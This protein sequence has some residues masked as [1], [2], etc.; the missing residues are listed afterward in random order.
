MVMEALAEMKHCSECGAMYEMGTEHECGMYEDQ[1]D[2]VDESMGAG[3]LAGGG[4]YILP[5]G[6]RPSGPRRD[7]ASKTAHRS[8]GGLPKPHKKR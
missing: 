3:A 6:I 5:L 8:F 1:E 4:G 7:S 2:D